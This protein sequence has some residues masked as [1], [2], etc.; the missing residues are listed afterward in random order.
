VAYDEAVAELRADELLLLEGG[1][2]VP[3]L[4]DLKKLKLP[5]PTRQGQQAKLG[6]AEI[7]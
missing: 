2:K 6:Q 7:L 5:A 4:E 3:E 1:E